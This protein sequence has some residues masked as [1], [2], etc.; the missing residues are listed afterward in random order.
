MVMFTTFEECFRT[1]L[2]DDKLDEAKGGVIS[3]INNGFDYTLNDQPESEGDP[4]LG[5]YPSAT[6]DVKWRV[7]FHGGQEAEAAYRAF[8]SN[9]DNGW[10]HPAAA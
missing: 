7:I 2:E 3:K 5:I 4:F 10:L 9:P 6:P 8:V 1:L